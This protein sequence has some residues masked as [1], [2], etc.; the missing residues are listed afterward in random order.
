MGTAKK[1]DKAI[2]N[3]KGKAR[4]T[5]K[6]EF[7]LPIGMASPLEAEIKE[8]MARQGLPLQEKVESVGKVVLREVK[9]KNKNPAYLAW[10]ALDIWR[11]TAAAIYDSW[12]DGYMKTAHFSE[13]TADSLRVQ[14][15][16]CDRASNI[17]APWC[18]DILKAIDPSPLL[19]F[20]RMFE[21]KWA[22]IRDPF[23]FDDLYAIPISLFNDERLEILFQEAWLTCDRIEGATTRQFKKDFGDSDSEAASEDLGG[24]DNSIGRMPKNP[25]VVA[26]CQKLA[27]ASARLAKGHTSESE[28]AFQFAGESAKSLAEQQLKASSLIRQARRYKHLWKAR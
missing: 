15:A 28:I 20:E 24:S 10:K 12:K 14:F 5:E 4:D 19:R 6:V 21:A 13:E 25:E 7:R 11:N 18:D 17:V 9:K 22:S 3:G 1:K 27:D 2:S 23:V 26:L 8:I 16:V